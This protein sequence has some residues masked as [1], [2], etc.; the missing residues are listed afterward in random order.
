VESSWRRWT[1]NS[2]YLG[3]RKEVKVP[4]KRLSMRKTREVLRLHFDLK[5]GQ[6]QIARSAQVSQ[7]TVHEYPNTVCGQWTEL[8]LAGR[9]R[10]RGRRSKCGPPLPPS[11]SFTGVSESLPCASFTGST[12]RSLILSTGPSSHQAHLD[13]PLP[14]SAYSGAKQG[15]DRQCRS[16]QLLSAPARDFMLPSFPRLYCR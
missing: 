8:A 6:G 10:W 3:L 11:R 1:F 16:P 12:L 15:G 2:G 9:A 14:R 7:S 13:W 5:P 4:G